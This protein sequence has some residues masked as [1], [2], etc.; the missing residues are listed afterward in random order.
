MANINAPGSVQD[1]LNRSM[2]CASDAKLGNVLAELLALANDVRSRLMTC[3]MSSPALVIK[4]GGST[5][6]K[7]SNAFLANVAG[8]IVRK[9]AATDMPALSGTLATAKS[10]AW[11]FYID[12]TGTLSVSTKTADAASHDAAVALL[13][14]NAAG[15]A[16]IGVLVLDNATG[17]NFVGGTTALDTASL[18]ATYYNIH[19]ANIGPVTTLLDLESRY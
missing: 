7:A 3:G 9:P 6:V 19:G 11:A 15:K 14:Q 5:L 16:L 17:S 2:P 18:T 12:A 10:A 1:A 4:T 13:P 8:V